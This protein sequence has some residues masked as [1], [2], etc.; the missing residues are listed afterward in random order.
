MVCCHGFLV[1]KTVGRWVFFQL[2]DNLLGLLVLLTNVELTLRVLL[3]I[4]CAHYSI[5]V[6]LSCWIWLVFSWL[7]SILPILFYIIFL[8]LTKFLVSVCFTS[9]TKIIAC[10]DGWPTMKLL[11]C[12]RLWLS[13]S[14]SLH[15]K[16]K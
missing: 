3:P 10:S 1:V 7:R 16:V 5:C 2:R 4:M 13:L 9:P 12:R 6:P 11:S 8:S 15:P 14:I